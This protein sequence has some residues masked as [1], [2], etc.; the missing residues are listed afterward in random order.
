MNIKKEIKK[1]IIYKHTTQEFYKLNKFLKLTNV[2]ILS[3]KEIENGYKVAYKYGLNLLNPLSIIYILCICIYTC[4]DSIK[5]IITDVGKD[6]YITE[7]K[8]KE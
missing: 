6:T 3:C 7:L 8:L 4:Y 2:K 5:D 1:A